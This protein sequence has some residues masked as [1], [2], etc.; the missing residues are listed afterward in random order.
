MA[1]FSLYGVVDHLRSCLGLSP[2]TIPVVGQ[3]GTLAGL[4]T[5]GAYED[6]VALAGPSW[7]SRMSTRAA[8]ALMFYRQIATARK[9][10][11]PAPLQAGRRDAV[12]PLEGAAKFAAK[13]G[14]AVSLASCDLDQFG[15]CSATGLQQVLGDQTAFVVR[16]LAHVVGGRNRSARPA[17]AAPASVDA[18]ARGDGP[19]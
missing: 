16:S 4:S 2:L 11:C 1:R 10:R 7:V 6:H 9:V 3:P 18:S 17:S 14:S 19:D 5:P 13:A 12:T 15:V 8:A